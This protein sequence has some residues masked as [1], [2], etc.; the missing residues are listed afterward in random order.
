MA[1]KRVKGNDSDD[2]SED[3]IIQSRKKTVILSDSDQES[4]EE[5]APIRRSNRSTRLPKNT[6]SHKKKVVTGCLQ[7]SED[8]ANDM[9]I[10]T[11]VTPKA[12]RMMTLAA[13]NK[14]VQDKKGLYISSGD[15]AG[16]DANI[17]SEDEDELPMFENEEAPPEAN[18]LTIKE[19]EGDLDGFVVGDNIIEEGSDE[20]EGS[21][22]DESPKIIKNR[23]RKKGNKS[24]KPIKSRSRKRKKSEC[25]DSSNSNEDVDGDYVNPYLK[26]GVDDVDFR[27]IMNSLSKNTETD[28]RN[29]KLY[30]KEMGR[31]QYQVHSHRNKAPDTSIVA[32]NLKGLWL[33]H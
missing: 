7:S 12:K 29:A 2:S 16:S 9:R 25:S 8:E 32:D 21:E 24:S 22:A 27:D 4:G 10:V 13:L 5:I 6:I 23:K 30:R 31:Y 28:K 33:T 26:D 15:E 1:K 11:G 20:N 19:E 3:E 17:D 14:K 18:Q